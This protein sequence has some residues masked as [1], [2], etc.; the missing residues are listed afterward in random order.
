LRGGQVEEPDRWLRGGNPWEIARPEYTQRVSYGGRS[1]V[2][3]TPD[4]TMKVRW[5]DTSD[6]LALPYDIPIPGFRNDMV[7]TLRL[8]KAA[9]TDEF[10][11]NDFNAGSYA[12]SVSTKNAAEN[13]TMVLYPND[14]S[15][16]GKE[17]RLK[18]Q[19]FLAS[20]KSQGYSCQMASALERGFS[21]DLPR[22]TA[23]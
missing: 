11:L 22:K 8:W 5:V 16:N 2:Y 10:D 14:A 23:S 18:Q 7:N 1:E 15:E 19:Y 12:E 20:A 9:A 4:G 3:K 21:V 13:I 17:L 6:I